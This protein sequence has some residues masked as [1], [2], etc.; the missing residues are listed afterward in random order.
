[1][2]TAVVGA[3]KRTV[4]KYGGRKAETECH[5]RKQLSPRIKKKQKNNRTLIKEDN[6]ELDAECVEVF[7]PVS[8]LFFYFIIL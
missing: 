8:I 4:E 5:W 2:G 3:G 7:V 1:M 6:K